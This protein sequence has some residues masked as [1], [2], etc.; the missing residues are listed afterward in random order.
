MTG[1]IPE[2]AEEELFEGATAADIFEIIGETPLLGEPGEVFN[3]SNL[4]SAASG[5]MA[6][7]VSGSS[8]ETLYEDYGQLLRERILDP[9]GMDTAT[10]SSNE[11]RQRPDYA[12]SYVLSDGE[13]VLSESYD[14]EGDPLAPSGALKANVVEM[15]QYVATQLNGGVAPNGNRVISTE[16]L[17]QTW[18][19]MLENYGMGW[20]IRDY[21][22]MEIISHT[23]SYDDFGSVIGFVPELGVGF[24]IL[25]N[26]EE[27]GAE[28]VE[29]A[30]YVLVDLLIE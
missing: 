27:A 19:P 16:T 21:G 11:V 22:G 30:P 7:L 12:L 18:E 25:L 20:E 6:A 26:C 8:L 4:S 15:A 28:L 2:E 17:Q 24:V 9:I 1:G 14:V 23:G 10:L 13:A 5:Y 3:Y 29:D